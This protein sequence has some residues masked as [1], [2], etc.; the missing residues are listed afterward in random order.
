ML[1]FRKEYGE[2]EFQPGEEETQAAITDS[3]KVEP[4]NTQTGSK[5]SG[6]DSKS[7]DG[8]TWVQKGL[9]FAVVAGVIVAYFRMNKKPSSRYA[10][11]SLA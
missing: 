8:Y 4:Q 7:I 9:F 5:M 2:A 3:E 10:D 6:N 1:I 11:K